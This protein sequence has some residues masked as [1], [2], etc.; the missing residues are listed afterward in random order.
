MVS[1][2]CQSRNR[3]TPTGGALTVGMYGFYKES[4]YC[5]VT[6]VRAI[7]PFLHRGVYLMNFARCEVCHVLV[8]STRGKQLVDIGRGGS[9]Q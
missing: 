4:C 5:D 6:L 3:R 7:E 8:E 2:R 1:Q 9:V